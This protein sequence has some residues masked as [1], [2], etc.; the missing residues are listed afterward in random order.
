MAQ[1]APPAWPRPG[2]VSDARERS[3]NPPVTGTQDQDSKD[4]NQR[5]PPYTMLNLDL[6]VSHFEE[7]RATRDFFIPLFQA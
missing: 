3:L 1:G 6:K 7:K 5:L 4:E 2:I